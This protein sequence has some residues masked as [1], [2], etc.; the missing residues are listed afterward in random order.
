MFPKFHTVIHVW[1]CPPI[2]TEPQS[3]QS[4]ELVPGIW[5]GQSLR[6]AHEETSFAFAGAV[7]RREAE[8]DPSFSNS[9]KQPCGWHLGGGLAFDARNKKCQ[10][11]TMSMSESSMVSSFPH[12]NPCFTER[13]DILGGI[14]DTPESFGEKIIPLFSLVTK[15]P[16]KLIW[17]SKANTKSQIRLSSS[18]PVQ[19]G[20]KPSHTPDSL[21]ICV[22]FCCPLK[23]LLLEN[24]RF[25]QNLTNILLGSSGVYHSCGCSFDMDHLSNT[26]CTLSWLVP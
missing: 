5:S 2:R 16:Q 11:D 20:F 4:H 21:S 22:L 23:S 3:L 25:L 8:T 10:S 15:P 19:P 6:E 26:K 12:M 1:K 9:A 13:R 14:H 24:D 18:M 7:A 17:P